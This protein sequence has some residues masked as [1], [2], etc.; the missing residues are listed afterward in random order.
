M[1]K[2][3]PAQR[4]LRNMPHHSERLYALIRAKDGQ[5]EMCYYLQPSVA[6]LWTSVVQQEWLGS[7]HTV[8]SLRRQGWVARPVR[9]EEEGT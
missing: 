5:T 8:E 2:Q 6:D 3:T 7:G 9:V 1:S 4:R